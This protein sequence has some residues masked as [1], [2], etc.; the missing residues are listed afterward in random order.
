MVRKERVASLPSQPQS[1]H[2]K[3]LESF[4]VTKTETAMP[5][6]GSEKKHIKNKTRKQSFHGI[7]PGFS[8][9]FCLFVCLFVCLCVFF[10]SHKE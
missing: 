7:V 8:G 10:L 1:L 2:I 5:I 6:I 4:A 3:F 9:G